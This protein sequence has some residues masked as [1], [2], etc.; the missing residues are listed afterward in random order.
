M[1]LMGFCF[2]IKM[3]RGSAV[4]MINLGLSCSRLYTL[5]AELL[6]C[7]RNLNG[8]ILIN[9]MNIFPSRH[10]FT[11]TGTAI[12]GAVSTDSITA[13]SMVTLFSTMTMPIP[14]ISS[15]TTVATVIGVLQL[16]VVRENMITNTF[17]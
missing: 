11:G 6:H 3:F 7:Y 9:K 8:Y 14:T 5:L 2:I 1:G 16:R 4:N 10:M 15:N 12:K 17:I 13:S